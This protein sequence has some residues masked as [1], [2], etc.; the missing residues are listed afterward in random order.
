LHPIRTA[1]KSFIGEQTVSK[2]I[3]EMT[4]EEAE[5]EVLQRGNTKKGI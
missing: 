5:K 3:A 4:I 1:G 2:R